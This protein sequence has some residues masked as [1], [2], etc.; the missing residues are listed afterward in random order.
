MGTHTRRQRLCVWNRSR[1]SQPRC[2]QPC[3]QEIEK[4]IGLALAHARHDGLKGSAAIRSNRMDR[5][6]ASQRWHARSLEALGLSPWKPDTEP[7]V[8][9]PA[10]QM[11][12][13]SCTSIN[14]LS[15]LPIGDLYTPSTPFN[16]TAQINS[17]TQSRHIMCSAD[18]IREIVCVFG[19]E[20]KT[21]LSK[22]QPPAA[23]ESQA[24]QRVYEANR[25][26]Q[27]EGSR[28]A[29]TGHGSKSA[30]LVCCVSDWRRK[31]VFKPT[32]PQ[33]VE[34]KDEKEEKG[35]DNGLNQDEDEVPEGTC[36]WIP[37]LHCP[38]KR[39]VDGRRIDDGPVHQDHKHNS[40]PQPPS[41]RNLW[42][43]TRTWSSTAPAVPVS[44]VGV[45]PWSRPCDIS[46]SLPPCSLPLP[47]Q[48]KC[49]PL[50]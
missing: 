27:I 31:R 42:L 22:W 6:S 35:T 2:N 14:P 11:L 8:C 36:P 15:S 34:A 43:P 7:L 50:C 39:K 24:D 12:K 13:S 23:I 32:L 28:S 38:Q 16:R 10:L 26:G 41:T 3:P 20:P 29:G 49:Q 18:I 30:T 4:K 1:A 37:L 33:A 45:R 48:I 25:R 47:L 9:S 46:T 40:D 17:I 44:S 5:M 19:T 21:E